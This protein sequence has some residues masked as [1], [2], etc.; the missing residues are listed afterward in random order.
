VVDESH[1]RVQY[2]TDLKKVDSALNLGA[3]LL[4]VFGIRTRYITCIIQDLWSIS[5]SAIHCVDIHTI[6]SKF[7]ISS[8]VTDVEIDDF[9]TFEI[10]SLRALNTT[11][12]SRLGIS[13]IIESQSSAEKRLLPCINRHRI[14]NRVT[15]SRS[16]SLSGFPKLGNSLRTLHSYLWRCFQA[17]F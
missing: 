14:T 12:L 5:K 1:E 9:N 4:P 10:F 13:A 2:E 15:F 3:R 8:C 16:S 6:A 17:A 7:L 11:P